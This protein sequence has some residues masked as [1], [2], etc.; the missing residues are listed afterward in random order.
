MVLTKEEIRKKSQRY[1]DSKGFILNPDEKILD[2]VLEG[3]R[4]NEEKYGEIYC[5][6][7]FVTGDKEKDKEG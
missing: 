1:A 4:R 7:R 5:P 3:L 2:I 6:C